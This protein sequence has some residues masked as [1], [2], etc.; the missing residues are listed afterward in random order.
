MSTRKKLYRCPRPECGDIVS[1]AKNLRYHVNAHRK[2][3][4]SVPVVERCSRLEVQVEQLELF[5]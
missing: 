4:E 5:A 2:V 1:G 3:G